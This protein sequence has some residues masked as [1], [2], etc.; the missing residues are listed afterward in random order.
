MREIYHFGIA[1]INR[2]FTAEYIDYHIAIDVAGST[3]NSMVL[4]FDFKSWEEKKKLLI[5]EVALRNHRTPYQTSDEDLKKLL[6]YLMGYFHF[7]SI[8]DL[9]FSINDLRDRLNWQDREYKTF[10]T[11][12]DNFVYEFEYWFTEVV[13]PCLKQEFNLHQSYFKSYYE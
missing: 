6:S 2:K 5:S 9:E 10:S 7:K 11:R 13:A 8:E 4:F 12:W 1:K 3:F